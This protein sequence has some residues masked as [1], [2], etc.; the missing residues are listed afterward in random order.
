[1]NSFL[2]KM[3]VQVAMICSVFSFCVWRIV[4]YL[5]K[6]FGYPQNFDKWH[7]I[8]KCAWIKN[9]SVIKL[10]SRNNVMGFRSPATKYTM[11]IKLQIDKKRS[12]A[13]KLLIRTIWQ[14]ADIYLHKIRISSHFAVLKEVGSICNKCYRM[15][16]PAPPTSYFIVWLHSV[17]VFTTADV[18]RVVWK[19]LIT[20]LNL[21][22]LFSSLSENCHICQLFNLTANQ[23]NWL[24]WGRHEKW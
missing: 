14:V 15:M 6:V 3:G 20:L 9:S 21:N 5:W 22:T 17:Q 1:M 8:Q 12:V 4:G 10:W 19:E 11:T 7:F 16:Y 24:A 23:M 18:W 13:W 2:E